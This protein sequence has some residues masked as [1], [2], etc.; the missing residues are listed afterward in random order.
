MASYNPPS[1][2]LPIFDNSVFTTTNDSSTSGGGLTLAQ[3]NALYL[4]K[5]YPD[6]CTAYETFSAGLETTSFLSTGTATVQGVFYANGG[7][8]GLGAIRTTADIF[9][10]GG[11]VYGKSL[12]TTSNGNLTLGTG[13]IV[14]VKDI[15]A[16]GTITGTF[17]GPTSGNI[18]SNSIQS[19]LAS[20]IMNIATTQ[21]GGALNIATGA[22]TSN[23]NIGTSATNGQMSIG[24]NA[25]TQTNIYGGLVYLANDTEIN[26]D[27]T[28]T[29]G[30]IIGYLTSA[31]ASATYLTLVSATS[32]YAT[33]ASLSSYLTI[34]SASSTYATIASLS[35]YLTTASAALTYLTIT[36]ASATYATITALG[37]YLTTAS[38]ALTYLTITNASSTYATLTALANYL[39][40]TSASATY[41]TITTAS[42]TYAT[43]TA[44]GSYLTTASAA[45]TYLTITDASST[46]ATLT[47][48]ANYLT[49]TSASA[50][51]LTITNASSTYATLTALAN[52][53]TI[54]SASATYAPKTAPTFATSI[55]LTSGNITASSG[56][57]I[58]NGIIRNNANNG[59]ISSAGAIAGTSLALGTGNIST[60]KDITSSGNISTATG[61]ITGATVSAS[62]FA[63]I[64]SC[65]LGLNT[66]S[67]TSCSDINSSGILYCD[68]INTNLP[69]SILNICQGTDHTGAINIATEPTATCDGIF[70]GNSFNPTTVNGD[71]TVLGTLTAGGFTPGTSA[72][73]TITSVLPSDNVQ[74]Y[75]NQTTG[76]LNIGNGTDRTGVINIGTNTTVPCGGIYMG[77]SFNETTVNGDLT[78]IGTLTAGS[79]VTSYDTLVTT[80]ATT[81]ASLYNNQTSGVINMGTDALRTGNINIGGSNALTNIGGNLSLTSTKKISCN[82]IEATDPVSRC[83]LFNNETTNIIV[84][85]DGQTTGSLYLGTTNPAVATRTGN[86]I[87]GAITC[88]TE[89]R[90]IIQANLG[91]RLPNA[92]N[93]IDTN[94]SNATISLFDTLSNGI[95]NIGR[96]MTNKIN[97]GASDGS[98][99]INLG[100][101]KAEG[102]VF[103][104][105]DT[106]ATYN[107]FNNVGS[108]ILNICLG[109]SS[110][111]ITIG[112]DMV[113]GDV[114]ICSDGTG[115]NIY[116]GNAGSVTTMNGTTKYANGIS[117][118]GLVT[119]NKFQL[120]YYYNYPENTYSGLTGPQV[121]YNPTNNVTG[122]PNNFRAGV[123]LINMTVRYRYTGNPTALNVGF[124]LGATYGVLPGAVPTG[125][126]TNFTPVSTTYS[127][128]LIAGSNNQDFCYSHPMVVSCPA[129]GFINIYCNI[130]VLTRTGGSVVMST[131]GTIQRIA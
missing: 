26:G 78:V 28:M 103:G 67:I 122:G 45:L 44:L 51:Y 53:L 49:I 92:T 109:I 58:A 66:G 127:R 61:S 35:S 52:Y 36:N 72:L 83:N 115:G 57:I 62:A 94:T 9:S 93:L 16:S 75:E 96:Y 114:K 7:I 126:Y 8:Q 98:S 31:I 25:N 11:K 12:E 39:T 42:A 29:S 104:G 68:E 1:E 77:N 73:N 119:L 59:S 102:N 38:A 128:T 41:L 121:L 101:F 111:T 47:A 3:A 82:N 34:S 130:S 116:V 117:L 13:N 123:Y 37:S 99:Q 84:I 74:L 70:M 20:D 89:S 17:S 50:T 54:T 32:T 124:N 14:S 6:T 40:I 55:T 2:F 76:Q 88:N 24:S 80:T 65:N 21:T 63:G 97:I 33:I 90:G 129:D 27:L 5:T 23:V 79:S 125:T 100:Y 120:G 56:N 85:G 95:L 18:I 107:L 131:A 105:Y 10:T 15:T 112:R 46:Y 43:L 30:T 86:V 110:G 19:V 87:L 106:T 91:I 60:V 118:G 108:G 48:L 113:S 81:D 64:G 4:R 69:D 22:R 71:L